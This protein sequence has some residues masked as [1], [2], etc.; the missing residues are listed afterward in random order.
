M[1]NTFSLK[2]LSRT[3]N[4]ESHFILRQ[5]KFDLMARFKEIKSVNPRLN[6]NK[7]VQVLE[8]SSS[9]LQRYRQDINMLSPCRFPLICHI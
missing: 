3:G 9:S 5:C 2:Q 1:N 4:L 7:T 8:C 6:Q